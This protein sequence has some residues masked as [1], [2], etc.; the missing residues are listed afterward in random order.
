ML[1]GD[2][3]LNLKTLSSRQAP[4]SMVH[5]SYMCSC[6]A[7]LILCELVSRICLPHIAHSPLLYAHVWQ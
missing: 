7:W 4:G 2:L 6:Q 3:L 1:H 5:S